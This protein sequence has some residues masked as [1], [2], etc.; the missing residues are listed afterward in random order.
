MPNLP[1]TTKNTQ[2]KVKTFFDE[3]YS[4]PLEF[5]SNEVDAVIGFFQK[6]GFDETSAQTVAGILMRQAKIDEVKVFELL[7]TLKGV[8][9]LHLSKVVTEI[10]NYNRQKMS[11]LGYKIEEATNRL[12]SRNI[13]V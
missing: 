3:F 4:Q 10:L 11:S 2:Q 7:D 5:P 8:D 6:R 1:L 9:D 12:E 13:L